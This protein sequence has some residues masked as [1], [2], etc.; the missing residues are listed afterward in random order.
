MEEP[1]PSAHSLAPPSASK[2][3][4]GSFGDIISRVL[5]GSTNNLAASASPDELVRSGQ[6]VELKNL[7]HHDSVDAKS[8]RESGT[9]RSLL[10]LAAASNQVEVINFLL[11]EC[12]ININLQDRDGNTPLHLAVI[13]GHLEATAA[14]LSLKPNDTLC[15]KDHNPP[16]HIAIRQGARGVKMVSEFTRHPAVSLFVRGYHD[17]TSL[18]V[19]GRTNNVKAL[20]V[21][22]SE[23]TQSASIASFVF[24]KNRHRRLG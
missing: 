20:E 8:W 5:S 6:L 19:I 1:P 13:G 9:K 22:H 12:R 21:I 4:R 10:H 18:H 23:T 3:H 16:L 24:V 15:N 14:I 2:T 7:V 11:G 17:N